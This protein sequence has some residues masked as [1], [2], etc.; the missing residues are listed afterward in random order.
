MALRISPES[1]LCLCEREYVLDDRRNDATI[2]E[3]RQ[4]DE[5]GAIRLSAR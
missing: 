5:L 4:L 2:D 1:L 3:A